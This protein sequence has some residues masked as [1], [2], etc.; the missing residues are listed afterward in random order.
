VTG[1]VAHARLSPGAP[2]TAEQLFRQDGIYIKSLVRRQLGGF[3][4]DQDVEDVAAEIVYRIVKRKVIGM[5]DPGHAS[6]ARW[7][8][9]LGRQVL[10]YCQGMGETL[11]RR[12]GRELSILD[13]T[14]DGGSMRDLLVGASWDDYSRLEDEEF[15]AEMRAH[16]ARAPGWQ[17]G[18]V[19]LV[20]LFDLTVARLRAGEARPIPSRQ[21]VEDSLGV[22]ANVARA[23]L[24]M[25]RTK[26]T[27][28]LSRA[29]PPQPIEV[30]G[31]ELTV[32][33]ARAA[34]RALRSSRGNRVA[35]ALQAVDSPLAGLGTR[36]FIAVGR[37]EVREHPE[38]KVPKGDK[39]KHGSQTKDALI[40]LLSRL[41]SMAAPPQA[42]PAK[43]AAVSSKLA[44]EDDEPGLEEILEA[45]LWRL[46][47][48][49]KEDIEEIL[50]L[51][52]QTFGEPP[53]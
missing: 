47:G 15:L 34:L 20:D 50:Q 44:G 48:A 24:S 26:L 19:S 33:Q 9:F 3:A 22:S 14:G 32:P 27:Q 17:A 11:G 52:K 31:V 51:A 10:L 53:A 2:E 4:S 45:R 12:R 39:S 49:T 18:S 29:A 40:H 6:G 7:R 1:P 30:G 43:S 23:G 36:E 8:T 42:E 25:F 16:I 46:K 35:P 13:D 5:Y 37:K 28:L 38:C 21:V 41:L